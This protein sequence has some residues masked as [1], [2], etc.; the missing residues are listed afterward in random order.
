M[1]T[2]FN[3][4]HRLSVVLVHE[5]EAGIIIIFKLKSLDKVK[6]KKKKLQEEKRKE[7]VCRSI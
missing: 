7:I 4:N 1:N 6:N 2:Q 3:H 5:T